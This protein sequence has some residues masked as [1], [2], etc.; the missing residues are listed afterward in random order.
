MGKPCPREFRDDIVRVAPGQDPSVTASK[1][2][3]ASRTANGLD[4]VPS[5]KHSQEHYSTDSTARK[6]NPLRTRPYWPEAS[7]RRGSDA[8]TILVSVVQ[9]SVTNE[10]SSTRAAGR[11]RRWRFGSHGAG[12]HFRCS[13]DQ[14]PLLRLRARHRKVARVNDE[15]RR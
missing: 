6:P 1:K 9:S 7:A 10:V 13:R 5:R 4:F 2:M 15:L 3:P 12:S 14:P 8:M 11:R